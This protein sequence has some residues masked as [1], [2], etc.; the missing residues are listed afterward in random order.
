MTAIPNRSRVSFISAQNLRW[1][2]CGLLFLATTINYIDRQS[3][4]ML[5]PI[6]QKNL[7][8]NE[9]DYGWIN[10][11]FQTAYAVMQPLA[12]RV[13]DLIG[14]RSALAIGVAV[15]SLA[16]LSHAF[17]RSVIGF[18]IARFALGAGEAMNFPASLKAVA[19]WF[20]RRERALATGLFNSGA[21]FGVMFGF[22]SVYLAVRFGW[23][24]AFVVIAGLGF[25]WVALWMRT[26]PS[27]PAVNDGSSVGD[28]SDGGSDSPGPA[29][30]VMPKGDDRPI[31]WT[32]IL[33]HREAWPFILTKFLSD[34]V[35]WFY[36]YWLPD[37]LV[38]HRGLDPKAAAELLI[39]PYVAASV[40]SIGFGWL[41]GFLIRRGWPVSTARYLA[42]GLC[43]A[44]MPGAIVASQTDQLTLVVVLISFAA[45]AHQGWAAN[46]YS[47][48]TDVFPS[49]VAGS[50][51]GIGQSTGA[52]GGMFMTLLVG[53]VLQARQDYT[54]IFLWAGLMHP[55]G[56]VVFRLIA[57][58][59]MPLAVLDPD[60]DAEKSIPLLIAGGLTLIAGLL[61]VRLIAL[62]WDELAQAAKVSGA[63]GGVVAAAGVALI[64]LALLYAGWSHKGMKTVR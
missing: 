8:W 19:E 39:I 13:A 32:V 44:C 29:A 35:W 40:G 51:I 2:V 38:K 43:A 17:V 52:I 57:G 1:W 53:G 36:L 21:N 14:V 18:S 46:L 54:P 27:T 7:G 34:P 25:L 60:A 45:A 22:I 37:Y 28:A 61:G 47:M 31:P 5:K 62:H 15:W 4:A 10:F 24:S 56:W 12:G 63:A 33:R 58:A 41:S 42:L 26:F 30:P 3:L 11:A 23:P 16:A 9:A 49:R 64:G 50:V 48:A 20:P 59:K 6:V 55:L